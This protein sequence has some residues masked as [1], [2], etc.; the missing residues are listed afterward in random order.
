[1]MVICQVVYTDD[2]KDITAKS[3]AAQGAPGPGDES[4]EDDFDI[5]NI[6]A[7]IPAVIDNSRYEHR[8][9]YCVL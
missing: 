9:P 3:T 5:D 7:C 4:G 8:T 6:W 1:M 2:G